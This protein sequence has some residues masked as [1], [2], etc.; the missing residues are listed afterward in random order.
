MPKMTRYL[1]RGGGGGADPSVGG[2]VMYWRGPI[3]VER[4]LS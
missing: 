4:G 2:H 3:R 1:T